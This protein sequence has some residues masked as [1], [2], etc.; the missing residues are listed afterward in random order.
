MADGESSLALQG[1]RLL[2]DLGAEIMAI[3][4]R[5]NAVNHRWLALIAEFDSRAGWA[6]AG[7]LLAPIG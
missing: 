5:V 2:A 4:N 1:D 6:E 7:A 3:A